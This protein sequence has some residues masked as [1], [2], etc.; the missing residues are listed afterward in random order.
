MRRYAW[1]AITIVALTAIGCGSP[2]YTRPVYTVTQPTPIAPPPPPEPDRT[3]TT[4]HMTLRLVDIKPNAALPTMVLR[5]ERTYSSRSRYSEILREW[6]TTR[7]SRFVSKGSLV[8]LHRDVQFGFGF[9]QL[10]LSSKDGRA[11]SAPLGLSLLIRNSSPNGVQV[12][13]NTVT[14]V[15]KEGRAYP[16]IH[17]GVKMAEGAGILG[18]STIPPGATLED[19]IYPRELVSFRPS[20]GR[21]STAYWEGV[22]YFESMPSGSRFMVYLPVKLGGE[23]IEYQFTFEAGSP[24]PAA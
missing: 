13:W 17:R 14:I 5:V 8:V 12:D 24:E 6:S 7:T 22:S 18:S 21:Y 9:T 11:S 1:V 19:F 2:T 20:T 23:A 4:A 3:E 15:G 16:V 10:D